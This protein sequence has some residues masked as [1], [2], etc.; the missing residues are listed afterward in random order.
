MECYKCKK[1]LKEVITNYIA[2]LGEKT[3]IV[4]NTPTYLCQNCYEQYYKDDVIK[5]VEEIM[6]KVE[7][8]PIKVAVTDYKKIET[9]NLNK[10]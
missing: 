7:E 6:E 1:E 10:K 8:L 3:V 5:N 9:Y 2:R 4:E